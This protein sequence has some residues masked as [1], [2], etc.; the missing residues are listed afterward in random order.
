MDAA[1]KGGPGGRAPGPALLVVRAQGRTSG[2][3]VGTAVGATVGAAVGSTVGAVRVGPAVRRPVPAARTTVRAAVSATVSATV[4]AAGATIGGPVLVAVVGTVAMVVPV[5]LRSCRH[6]VLPLSWM[7]PLMGEPEIYS[8][9]RQ[10]AQ[11]VLAGEHPGRL[12]VV[13]HEERIGGLERRNRACDRFA[14]ADD[15]Q[16]S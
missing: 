11:Q 1:T 16:R 13:V 3:A 14:G 6:V 9:G 4:S 7:S 5:L 2:T 10:E 8:A 12:P 15:R